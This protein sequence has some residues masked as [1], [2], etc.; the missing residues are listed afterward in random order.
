MHSRW[1]RITLRFTAAILLVATAVR[2]AFEL[3]SSFKTEIYARPDGGM[4]IDHVFA[5]NSVTIMI[6]LIGV[7]LLV[8]SI[9]APRKTV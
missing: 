9:L 3:I 4:T 7:L 8:F 1:L 6:G 2:F 5:F